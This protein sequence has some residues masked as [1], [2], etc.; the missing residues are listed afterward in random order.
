MAAQ[1]QICSKPK[2]EKRKRKIK[3]KKVVFESVRLGGKKFLLT[4]FDSQ[5]SPARV[6]GQEEAASS[7][8]WTI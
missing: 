2:E 6:G 4:A 5:R 1:G 7:P 3:E 8:E